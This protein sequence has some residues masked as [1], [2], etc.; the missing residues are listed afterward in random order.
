[1]IQS[2]WQPAM[3]ARLQR[4]THQPKLPTADLNNLPCKFQHECAG[5]HN[6]RGVRWVWKSKIKVV[7]RTIKEK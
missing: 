5:S 2:H 4:P 7:R 1:M 6:A 3:R